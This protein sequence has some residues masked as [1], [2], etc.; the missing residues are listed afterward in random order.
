MGGRLEEAAQLAW[1]E[2]NEFS[3]VP[4]SALAARN[5]KIQPLSDLVIKAAICSQAHHLLDW[6]MKVICISNTELLSL[7]VKIN[8]QLSYTALHE[9]AKINYTTIL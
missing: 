6:G 7:S 2:T 9:V 1:T 3:V 5:S 4:A 8:G